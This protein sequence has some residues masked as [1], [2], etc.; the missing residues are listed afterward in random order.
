MAALHAADPSPH[1]K[2]FVNV[3][4][5]KGYRLL[6]VLALWAPELLARG[7]QS[8]VQATLD[9]WTP[10]TDSPCGSCDECVALSPGGEAAPR[11]AGDPS[12]PAGSRLRLL[13]VEAAQRTFDALAASPLVAALGEG[14]GSSS[15]GAPLALMHALVR[16]PLPPGAGAAGQ[17]PPSAAAF[18]HCPPGFESCGG[19]HD[20]LPTVP[21]PATTIDALLASLPSPPPAAARTPGGDAWP[22]LR[23]PVPSPHAAPPPSALRPQQQQ[24]EEEGEEEAVW[25][26]VD[27][28]GM[29]AAVVEGSRLSIAAGRVAVLEFEY[30]SVGAWRARS[31]GGLVELLDALGMTCFM[32]TR[33]A[34]GLRLLT[35]CWGPAEGGYEFHTWSTVLCASRRRPHL[36]RALFAISD[37]PRGAA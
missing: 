10:L 33:A 35:G 15:A 31:L 16:G 19:A 9:Y 5:N 1:G 30:H 25:L 4:A 13:A 18:P 2:L 7:S 27:A 6:S 26:L 36:L 21:T 3:G 11:G 12:A 29:D 24:Q 22:A 32:P 37:V 20:E 28:E 23:L 14:S 17:G 34:P 8:L